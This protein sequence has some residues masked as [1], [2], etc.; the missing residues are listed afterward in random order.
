M[1]I[2][3]KKKTAAA[4]IISAATAIALTMSFKTIPTFSG[5]KPYT[6]ILDAGHGAPR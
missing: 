6:V 2:K 1:I 4:I 3:I 5:S